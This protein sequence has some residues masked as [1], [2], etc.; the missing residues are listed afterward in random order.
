[1]ESAHDSSFIWSNMLSLLSNNVY[2]LCIDKLLIKPESPAVLG[3]SQSSYH[4]CI[5]HG[6]HK[7]A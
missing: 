7:I 6:S 3:V 2:M 1:M 5:L 4:A